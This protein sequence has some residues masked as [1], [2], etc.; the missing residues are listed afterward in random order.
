MLFLLLNV[1]DMKKTKQKYVIGL[2]QWVRPLAG[3]E[4]M[5]RGETRCTCHNSRGL[6]SEAQ[7]L[8][9]G[10][11]ALAP[12]RWPSQYRATPSSAQPEEASPEQQRHGRAKTASNN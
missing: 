5:Y 8:R 4:S 12:T 2:P 7:E 3:E 6:C 1:M 9:Q 10:T 11:V